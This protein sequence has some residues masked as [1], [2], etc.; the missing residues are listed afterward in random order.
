MARGHLDSLVLPRLAAAIVAGGVALALAISAVA[1]G[2]SG[3]K[4]SASEAGT[5]EFGLTETQ[6]VNRIESVESAIASCMGDAGFKYE[7]IDPVTLRAAMAKLGSAP[8]LSDKQFVEQFGYRISTLPPTADFGVGEE[9]TRIYNALPPA[10]RVAYKR[11]LL[12]EHPEATFMVTLDAEDFS[13]TGG[14]TRAAVEKVFKPDQLS[15]TYRNP[16]D[17]LVEQDP[18]MVDAREKWA[19]CMRAKGYDYAR[20][21]DAEKDIAARLQR[22]TQGGD[23]ETLTGSA[24]TELQ[25][26][27]GEERAIAV[28]DFDCA[29]RFLDDVEERVVRDIT[30]REPN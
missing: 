6:L 13:Q 24:K 20:Q 2:S 14:C 1:C 22:I 15:G 3:T 29:H 23:P 4:S 9:N 10:D 18:R 7:P 5:A 17:V 19:G 26:L 12:G 27:Q 21:E 16:T 11:T 28:V 25:A 30:G 8:G